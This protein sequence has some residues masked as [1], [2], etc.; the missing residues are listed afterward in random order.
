VL[1]DGRLA[2]G[3]YDNTI[4]LW[5]VKAGTEGARLEVDASVLCLVTESDRRLIAG[6]DIGHADH[7]LP[8]SEHGGAQ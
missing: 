6:D 7:R 3:S 2:S 1:P 4:R 5:D 8:S